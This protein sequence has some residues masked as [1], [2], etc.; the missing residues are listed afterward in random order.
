[1]YDIMIGHL[2]D[3]ELPL[4]SDSFIEK[5]LAQMPAASMKAM[6]G[7]DSIQEAANQGFENLKEFISKMEG[8]FDK[9]D[10]TKLEQSIDT[11]KM[12]LKG[13]YSQN[14]GKL[15]KICMYLQSGN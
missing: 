9:E 10:Y 8:E 1:M 13:H 3:R 4:P 12:Y 15:C 11:V 6:S 14:I 7:V 2:V 5:L